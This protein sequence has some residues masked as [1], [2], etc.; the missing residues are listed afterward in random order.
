[1]FTAAMLMPTLAV[2]R[3]VSFGHWLRADALE[4]QRYEIL[5]LETSCNLVSSGW[6]GTG[7]LSSGSLSFG[8]GI[9]QG[10]VL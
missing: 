10:A 5:G 6:A 8:F 9:A 4:S 7:M 3:Q 1:M 2:T